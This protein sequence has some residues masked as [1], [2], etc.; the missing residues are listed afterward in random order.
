VLGGDRG[1]DLAVV[2]IRANR[3]ADG[4]A[5]RL[6]PLQVGQAAIAIGNPLGFE[7]TVTTGVVSAMDRTLGGGWRS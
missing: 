1:L 3:A 6:G 2:R 7:R 4:A 5:R